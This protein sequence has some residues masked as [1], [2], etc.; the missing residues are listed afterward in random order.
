MKNKEFQKLL[1]K[2]KF[3]SNSGFTLTELLVGLIMSIFVV[4]ALG[5]G[6]VQVL[7]TTESETSKVAVRNE[8]SRALDFISDEVRRASTIETDLANAR[9]TTSTA[10]GTTAFKVSNTN[11]DSATGTFNSDTDTQ[12]KIV[13][14]LDIPEVSSSDTL[15]T[16]GNAGTP[17]RIIYFLKSASGT[18][19][20]GPSVLYRW[21]P[22]LNADGTY[23]TGAWSEEALIDGIDD[24]H[25]AASPCA[26][27]ETL[28][29]PLLTGTAP[30][31][32]GAEL[33]TAATG[34]HAC[35]SGTNTAQLYLTGETD[36]AT[37]NDD[38]YTADTRVVARAR[39]ALPNR[40]N[41]FSSITWDFEDIGGPY[42]C[43][44][45]DSW[46]MRTDFGSDSSN[47]DD[48][49]KWIRDPSRQP[50]PI[51][52]DPTKP[53][54]ITSSPFGAIDCTSRGNDYRW[55]SST[56]AHELDGSNNP[57]PT[58]GTE[59][60]SKYDVKISY[61]IDFGDPVTFN[62][63]RD[64]TDYNVPQ[65]DSTKPGVQ[66]LKRGS[67][68]PMYGGFDENN[69]GDLSDANDQPTLGKFLYDQKLAEVKNPGDDPNDPATE[70]IIPETSS[71]PTIKILGEDQR[72][73]AFEVGQT[74][75]TIGGNPNPGFDLQD[76]IFIVTSDIFAKKFDPGCF[77]GSCPSSTP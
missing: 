52:V 13:F 63:D 72:I 62:G 54:T 69:D 40:V 8:T 41:N 73:L 10:P 71:D 74:D 43:S 1:K 3:K 66:F 49:I 22:P 57:I 67:D 44:T 48:T 23:G 6:L 65:V 20:E 27:G 77:T 37:G 18:N 36:T 9:I 76:N 26:A 61:T 14:A 15:D 42:H 2:N 7:R 39:T 55:D 68:V 11:I 47:P 46:Q 38:T 32:T 70:F 34:F 30:T 50:Q 5:F 29:P 17:E 35:I 56:S 58:D 25:I 28:T 16:D 53:L 64:G 19:W 21:G 51:A 45:S 4:G 60:L 24:T 33:S 31:L 59:P 75:A 12:K